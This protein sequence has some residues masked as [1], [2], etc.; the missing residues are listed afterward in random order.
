[1]AEAFAGEVEPVAGEL[2]GDRAEEVAGFLTEHTSLDPAQARLELAGIA[3]L[4]RDSAGALAGVGTV[5][6]ATV[7]MLG[8]VS[9]WVHRCLL[10]PEAADAEDALLTT[11]FDALEA[12]YEPDAGGPIGVCQVMRDPDEM[13]RTPEAVS[14]R[15]GLLHAGFLD[16]GSQVRIR[17]FGL[18]SIGPRATPLAPA[19][20]RTQPPELEERYR[21]EPLA[22]SD[23]TP[24]DVLAL[25]AREGAV[26]AAEAERRVHEVDLV[27]IDE[28]DGLVGISTSYLQ[29]NSQLRMDLHYFRAFVAEAHR[30]SSLAFLLAFRGR[31]HLEG[32]HVT[33][34]D[35][36]GAGIIYEVENELLKRYRN[37]A[38]WVATDFTYIGETPHGA[39][40]RV[41]YFP[42]AQVPIP[43][44]G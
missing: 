21:I 15:S 16:D 18:A 35:T 42:G 5:A 12:G 34:R 22:D 38:H 26:P 17:Y 37:E 40:V 2:A 39:H 10:V 13:R 6:E 9:L 44:P 4:A 24:D 3:S 30:R 27:A 23:A 33:G 32:L 31:D 8:G 41:H 20:E 43:G 19:A 29:R 1:M 11:A 14:P 36:R 28:E 25:W 7:P